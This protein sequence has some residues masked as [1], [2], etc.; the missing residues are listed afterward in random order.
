MRIKV[1]HDVTVDVFVTHTIADPDPKHNYT[2]EYYRVLQVK[3]LMEK[4]IKKSDA[5]VILLGGDFNEGPVFKKCWSYITTTVWR[6]LLSPT[7]SAHHS[8]F[9][10]DCL[11][12]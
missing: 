1:L 7:I 6:G 4:Y 2:N 11:Y 9:L 3:E 8:S 12:F 10:H 5:D